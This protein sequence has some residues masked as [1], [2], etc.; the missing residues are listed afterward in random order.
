VEIAQFEARR[1]AAFEAER[2]AWER[3]GERDRLKALDATQETLTARAAIEA[4]AGSEMIEA[5]LGGS[6]W[7]MSVKVGDALK[8]G[9]EVAV[10]EAMKAEVAVHC[11]TAGRVTAVYA[12]EGQPI[13]PGEA[14]IALAAN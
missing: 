13:Q 3:N 10:I 8:Q 11:A 7:K 1:N 2:T 9:A 12:R 14:L 5:P 4:P 6:L